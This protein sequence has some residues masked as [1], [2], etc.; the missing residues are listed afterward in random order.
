MIYLIVFALLLTFTLLFD[1]SNKGTIKNQSVASAY[2]ISFVA[3]T[4]LVGLRYRVGTDTLSYMDEY[5][6]YPISYFKDK[7]LI[8]W[9]LFIAVCKSLHL[10][11]YFVQLVLAFF[12]NF[13]VFSFLR[14]YSRHLFSSILLYYVIVF[15]ALNFEI[16]RQGVC[17][18]IFL[19]AFTLLDNRQYLKYFLSIGFACLFHY[20]ALLLLL[21]PLLTWIPFNRRTIRVFLILL[22]LVMVLAPVLKNQI[23]Q[24][25]MGLSFLEDRAFYY[26]SKVDAEESFSVLS[27]ILNL[28]L[29]VFIPLFVIRFRLYS[30]RIPGAFL[31]MCMFSMIIYVISLYMPIIYRLNNY[32]QLFNLVLF[33]DFFNWIRSRI[34]GKPFFVFL[35]CLLLFVGVKARVY[36]ARDEGTPVYYHYYP[37]SSVFNEFKVEQRERFDL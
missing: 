14:R 30:E 22:L 12:S 2:M 24:L 10:N 21:L 4:L 7:Y 16:L 26:F 5:Y 27:Y 20:S 32:F 17:I 35:V 36:F 15:P 6:K 33:V 3:L 19:L 18:S 31:I 29:N 1:Y 8:G 13:A 25:S 9:Y 11:F 34:K 23:Y 37:Y 28:T